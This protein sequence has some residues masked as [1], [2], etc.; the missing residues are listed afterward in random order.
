[1]KERWLVL[2]RASVSSSV[3]CSVEN[4][5]VSDFLPLPLRNGHSDERHTEGS[6][7]IQPTQQNKEEAKVLHSSLISEP[8]N[9]AVAVCVNKVW[10]KASWAY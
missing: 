5:S 3:R 8:Q 1:M 9:S 6:T 10:R 4:L 7:G 2:T